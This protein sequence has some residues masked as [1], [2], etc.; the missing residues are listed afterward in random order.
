MYTLLND[1]GKV[2]E[3][4]GSCIFIVR[5]GQLITPPVTASIL[6][7][8]TRTT[9]I[10]IARKDLDLNV[11]ERDIDR[12]ELYIADEIFMCGTAVEIVPVLGVDRLEVGNAVMGNVTSSIESL[13]FDI[14]RG[15]SEEHKCWLTP[16]Y[17]DETR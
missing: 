5:D 11:V 1:Q 10:D 4:P 14:V 2:S 17:K 6:E 8:I 15:L 16:I 9:I 12:T 3:G 13:Y 7:S